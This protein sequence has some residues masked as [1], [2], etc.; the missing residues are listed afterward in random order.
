LNFKIDGDALR[1]MN[2]L[3][4]TADLVLCDYG[5][6]AF[7]VIYLGKKLILLE[8]PGREKS[9]LLLNASNFELHEYVP[10]VGV[11]NFQIIHDMIS[12]DRLWDAWADRRTTLFNRYFADN[13]GTSSLKA[14]EILNNLDSIIGG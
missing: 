3:Y 10:A 14:V 5:G 4:K 7:S 11:E 6:S 9:P 13:R 1:D 2:K 8:V 12:D